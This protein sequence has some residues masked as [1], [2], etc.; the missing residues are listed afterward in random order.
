M[1]TLLGNLFILFIAGNDSTL[2]GMSWLLLL[3][4]AHQD[5]QKK[6]HDEIDKVVGKDGTI[7]HEDK[8]KLPYTM[9]TIFEMTR[10]VSISA[11]FPPR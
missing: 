6:V 2:A 8:F 5:I 4:A 7:Y 10:W 3:M 9:A 1:E 11:I